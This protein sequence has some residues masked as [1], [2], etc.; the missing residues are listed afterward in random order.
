M[1]QLNINLT[2][3]FEEDLERYMELRHISTKA[4]AIRTAIR[5]GINQATFQTVDVHF[6]KW[7]GLGLEVPINK[8]AKFQS[9]DDL[10]K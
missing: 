5:D 7:I 9:D 6:D 4:E 8:N 3:A 1:G 10:W 2:K